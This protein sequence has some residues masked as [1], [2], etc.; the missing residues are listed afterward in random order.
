MLLSAALTISILI[1]NL[2]INGL[3]DKRCYK[4]KGGEGKR[5]RRREEEIH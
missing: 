3:R 2:Y 4:R 1:S 5:E